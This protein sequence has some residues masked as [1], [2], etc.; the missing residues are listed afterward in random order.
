MFKFLRWL[1]HGPL[2][3]LDRGWIYLGRGYRFAIKKFKFFPSVPMKIGPYGPFRLDAY[4]AF[5]NFKH[6]NAGHNNG[7]DAC[8]AACKGRQCVVDIGAHIG[9]VT[10]P[11]STVVAD[12][13]QVLAFEPAIE[14]FKYLKKHVTLNKLKNVTLHQYLIG[15][16]NNEKVVFYERNDASGMNALIIKKNKNK[17]IQTQK[18][19]KT[20]DS[21]FENSSL[22]PELIKIDVEGAEIKVLKGAIRTL[23]KCKPIIFLSIHPTEIEL[24]GNSISELSDII[25]E[26]GYRITNID[27]TPVERFLL[28]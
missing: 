19:Q 7:F 5:S 24:L 3:C 1:R 21:F 9:L 10:L 8:I 15:D 28:K 20:L 12:N 17:Y 2:K 25:N 16:I 23:K 6:W 4:F 26:I 14:N 18:S 27:G 22:K 13:A 11:M